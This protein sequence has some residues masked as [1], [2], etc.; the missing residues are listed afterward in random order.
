MLDITP[1]SGLSE[2]Q[3]LMRQSCRDFV[4]DVVIPFIRG[5]W[6]RE[7]DMRPEARLPPEIL[8]GAQ[9]VGIRTLGVPEEFGGVELAHGRIR[10][11][12]GLAAHKTV[13]RAS[14]TSGV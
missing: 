5:N 9:Q 2:E 1:R 4:D 8:E 11:G 3:R 10:V 12:A 6:Q 14:L 7:W 13:I